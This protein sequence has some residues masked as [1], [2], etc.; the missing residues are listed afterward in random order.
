MD[1][2]YINYSRRKFNDWRDRV[3]KHLPEFVC[4]FYSIHGHIDYSKH[5]LLGFVI[6]GINNP[7]YTIEGHDGKRMDRENEMA[8]EV[9]LEIQVNELFAFIKANSITKQVNKQP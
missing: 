1:R 7:F 4:S 6:L 8:M 3:K 9:I 2:R 5:K